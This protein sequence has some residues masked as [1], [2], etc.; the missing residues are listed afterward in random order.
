[1]AFL[2]LIAGVPVVILVFVFALRID[3]F[4]S[5]GV[6]TPETIWQFIGTI[7]GYLGVFLSGYAVFEVK[8]LT[9]RFLD[10]QLFPEIKTKID[11]ITSEM[12]T[13][14][15]NKAVEL[16]SN[17]LIGK[18]RVLL[19][20]TEKAESAEI[21]EVAKRAR[22]VLGRLELAISRATSAKI[23]NEL[24]DYWELFSVLSEL[25]DQIDAVNRENGARL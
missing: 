12:N 7:F 24:T 9:R 14:S 5:N 13:I 2:L 18:I 3:L 4:V 19:K 25:G 1:M 10:K 8:R 22:T 21:V 17:R 20:Q 23:A 6:L 15:G 11:E 16:R